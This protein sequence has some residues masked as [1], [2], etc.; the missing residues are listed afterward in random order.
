M[1]GYDEGQTR[2]TGRSEVSRYLVLVARG[3][4]NYSAFVPDLSGCVATGKTRT[5]V[6]RQMQGAIE[7]HLE[8]LRE[9]GLEIP[10]PSTDAD[11]IEV[12]SD[13]KVV[14]G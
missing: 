12:D 10:E 13:V 6:L 3:G 8:G 4:R 11:W 9:D 5:A 7:M 2:D 14:A 1:Q